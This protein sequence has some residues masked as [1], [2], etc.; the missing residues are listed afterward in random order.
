MRQ[1][2]GPMIVA[3]APAL[4]VVIEAAAARGE[5]RRANAALAEV[6]RAARSADTL[7]MRAAVRLAEATIAVA[8]GEH[9][10][11]RPLLQD[12][13]DAFD[14]SE[15]PFESGLARLRLALCL[16]ALGRGGQAMHEGRASLTRFGALGA[17]APLTGPA[18]CSTPRA[19]A[20]RRSTACR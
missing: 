13:V 4:E 2:P 6:R 11:A 1:T 12:A 5:M 9:E 14:R 15:A 10:R 17:N 7:P 8:S 20:A 16:T 18:R 19:V 3:R